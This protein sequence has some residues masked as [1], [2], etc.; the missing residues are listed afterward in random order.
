MFECI[1][2]GKPTPTISWMKDNL[3]LNLSDPKISIPRPGVVKI[4]DVE[5]ADTG[6]F[7]CVA[8]SVMGMVYSKRAKLE[9]EGLCLKPISIPES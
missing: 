2:T 9:H 8:T 4:T 5:P 3:P 1:A 7:E 6:H